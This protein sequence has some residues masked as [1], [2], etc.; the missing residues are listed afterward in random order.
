MSENRVQFNTIVSNQLPA[1]VREDFPL[2]ESFLES[3]YRGQEYQGGPVD[4]IQNI[5]KYTKVDNTTNLSSEIILEGDIDFDDTT[6]NVST[7]KSPTGTDGFPDSYGLIQID[8]EII[9]Y[10]GKTN[11]SFTG[12]IRGF[13][14]ITS[15]RSEIFADEVVFN[16]TS[17]EDHDSG[18]TIKNLSVLFLKDFLVKTKHQI[19]PGFEER[20]LDPD[21]NQKLFLKQSKDFYLT[22][23][24]DRSFEILF[25]ALYNENVE[26]IKPRDNLVTP[27]N[28]NF[29]VLNEMVVEPISGNPLELENA[30]L[31]QDQYDDIIEKAYAPISSVEKVD[32][33][34][35]QTF[36]RLT[37]DGGYNRDI[38]VDGS[39][40]GEFKVE[41]TTK[42]IGQVSAG[43]TVLDVDSTVGFSTDG[44]LYVVY[45]D[46]TNGVLSYT[47]KSLTQF[48]GVSNVN[49]TITDASTV[50]VNTFAYA[51][52]FDGGNVRVRINSVINK[53]NVPSN[54]KGH[55]KAETINIT[56][57]GISENNKKTNNW[58]YNLAPI[59]KVKD[60]QLI[61]SSNFTY[62]ITLNVENIFNGG[63]TATL[64]VSDGRKLTTTIIDVKTEKS[65][66]IRGQGQLNT[67]ST[68][69]I[70]RNIS[71]TKSNFFPS[72]NIFSTDIQ[73]VYKSV[74]GDDYLVAS[75]SIPSYKGQPL[76]TNSREI[77]FTGTFNGTEFIISPGKDHGLY[78]GDKVYYAA[79]RVSET[80]ID[81]FGNSAT[82]LVRGTGL[83]AD[84]EYFIERVNSFTVRFA[85]SKNNIFNSKYVNVDTVTTVNNSVV[86]PFEFYSKNLKPQNILRKISDPSDDGSINETKP[87][88]T[89]I[90]VNGVEILNYKSKQ[91]IKYGSIEEIEVTSSGSDLDVVNPPEL[92]ISDSVGTGATGYLAINGSLQEILI[93][94][95]GFDYLNTPTIKIDGGNGKGAT[96]SVNMKLIDHEP[97]FF[98]DNAKG[99]VVI[100]TASTQSRIGFSTYH[101]FKNAEEVIYITNNQEGIAGIV[102]NAQ[103]YVSTIDDVTVSLHPKQNDAI[104][105]INTVFLS[106]FGVGKHSLKSTSKKSVVDSINVVDGGLGY[107]NK[108]RTAA[109]TSGVSTAS[110]T[111]IISNHDYNSGELV[112]YTCV[113][114][115]ISG[116]NVDTDYYITK[117]ND[118]SFKLSQ[119]GVT[120]DKQLYYRTK[121]YVNLTSVGVGTHVFNY[122]DITVTLKGEV[123]ISSI[124]S[125]TFE[126]S[127][128]PVF[129]GSVTSVHLE[130][131]GVGYGSSEIL[132]LDHQPQVTINSGSNCQLK[133]II[134]NGRIVQVI[135]QNS[136][137]GYNSPPD[138]DV[139]G[140]G[141]GA[142]I[143]L[144]IVNGSVS[145]VNIIEKGAG[146]S[147]DTTSIVI[148]PSGNTN[149]PKFKSNLKTWRV[150][151]FEKYLQYF[152]SDDGF[153]TD[154][155]VSS[156]ELQYAHLYAPRKLRE[157]I[158]AVDQEGNKLYGE[159][160]LR[161]VNGIEQ[162]S[163]KHSPIIGFAYDGNPIYGPY[164]YS[165]KS[166]GTITQLK[167]GY[168][169]DIKSNRPPTSIFPEGFFVE[170]YTHF[171]V[172]D[173]DVLDA[174]NGRFCITPEYPNGTYA[175]FTTINSASDNSGV[176]EK[177]KK[178][179]FPYLI[180]NS[181][182]SIPDEY[183][184]K[185][186]SLQE[187][188]NSDDWR[189]NTYPY[190]VIEGELE[191]SY[192]DVPNKL[193]QSAKI[194]SVQPGTVN[195][196]GI[197]SAGVDY[198]IGDQV[199][200]D[201][202]NTRGEGISAKVSHLKGR[203]VNTVSVATSTLSNVEIYS[204]DV[205]GEYVVYNDKPHNFLNFNVVTIAGLSTTSSKI[206]GTYKAGITTNRLSIV[207]TG[208]TGVAIGTVGV[209]GLVTFFGVSGDL[210]FSKVR[211]ND[212]LTIGE[213]K[214]QVLNVD[215]KSSRIRVLREVEGTT[216]TSHT[217]GKY[218]FEDPRKLIINAGFKTD[219]N[220]RINKQIYFNPEVIGLGTISGV[221][222]GTTISFSN[223]GA[224]L[225]SIFI[226]SKTIFIENHDLKT[227]DEITYSPGTGGSG[228]IVEDSTNVGVGIT[229]TDGQKVFVAKIDD[230][231][232]GIATVR[233]GLGTTGT[234]VGIASTH[235]SATTL[236]FRSVGS[237]TTHSFK[238]N[239]T[240]LTGEVRRNLV[241]VSAASTHGLSSPHNI[242]ISVSPNNTITKILKYNDFNRR[243]IVDPVGFTTVGVNT[244]NN[245]ISVTSHGFITGDKIIHTSSDPTQ[246][247]VDQKIYYIVK[248]DNNT[249]KLA[250]TKHD[251]TIEKPN[252]VGLSSA[253][254]GTINPINP[255]LKVYKN[256]TVEFDLSD[257]S[258]GYTVQGT[259]YPAFEFNLYT[260]KNFTK[261]W[262]KSDT[263][264]V[265]ELTKTGNVGS[266]GAK[267]TL[268]VNKNLP[269]VLYYK[270]DVIKESSTPTSK[271]SIIVDEEANSNNE[272]NC[273]FSDY[274][275]TYS[276]NVGTTTT[277]TYTL[278]DTPEST[279]YTSPTSTIEYE[280]DCT[281]TYGPIAKVSIETP[282]KNYYSLPGITTVTTAAGKNAILFTS[283]ND[284]GKVKNIDI[285]NIDNYKLPSDKTLSPTARY[286][287]ILKID[288]LAQI[289][290]V[291]ISSFGRGYQIAPKLI[292]I[293][294]KTNNVV[295]DIDLRFANNKIDILKNTNGISNATPTIIP[296]QTDSGV[297]INTIV[298]DSSSGNVDVTLSVGFS[299]VN[300]F[301][302]K[303]GDKVLV[304][305]VSVGLGS[306]GK[307]FDSANYNYKLFTLTAVT[308]NLGGIGSVRYNISDSLTGS[309]FPGTFDKVNSSGRITAEK[310]FAIF[311]IKL[312]TNNYI[313]GETVSSGSKVGVVDD[314]DPK[315][316]TLTISSNDVFFTTDVIKGKTSNISGI[317]TSVESFDINT[318]VNSSVKTIKG[319]QT[320][321]G[322]LNFDLQ[323][324]QDS[325]YYQNFSY[326]LKSRVDFDTWNDPVSTTNHTLGFRKF[327]DYQLES[328]NSN[329]MTV[330]VSTDLTNLTLIKDVDSFVS[331]NCVFDFDLVKENNFNLNNKLVSDE[332]I[333]SN[334]ILSDFFESVGNRVLSIDDVSSQ[335]NSNPRPTTFSVIN[336]FN[337]NEIRSQKYIT[338]VGDKRF[339]AQRQLLLIDLIHDGSRGYINQ[340]GRVESQ[341]DQGS[342][343]FAIASGQGELRFFPTKFKVNDYNVVALSYNLDDVFAGVGTTSLGGVALIES[344]SSPITAGVTTNIVSI[345]STYTSAKVL[346]QINPDTSSNEEFETIELN[347]VHDGSNVELLDY[348]R[349]STGLAAYSEVGLGTYHAYIDGSDLKVDFVPASTGIGTTGVIN[350]IQVGLASDTFTG[351]GTADL[352]NSRIKAETTSISSSATPGIN[353]ISQ[354]DGAFDG[355]YFLVQ[356][357][358]TTNDNYQ[359]SEIVLLDDYTTDTTVDSDTYMTEYGV[360]ETSTTSGFGTFGS[361]V[362]SAGTVSL[363]YT[364]PAS[365]NTVV[366]VYSNNLN[367]IEDE[368]KSEE[369][370]FTNGSIN[371]SL[372]AYQGTES[373][374]KREFELK[375]ENLQ[376]FERYFEGNDSSIVS[377]TNNTIKI[378]NHFFVS[379]EKIRYV[380][381][382]STT[383][384]V[385]IATTS[386]V[387]ASSTTFLPGEN[388][389]AVKVDD[390]NIKIAS[391]A[392]NA[393]KSIPQIVELESVG[394]GTSHRFIA[395]NQNAKVIVAIDNLIQSP[396]VSTAVTTTLADS[397]TIADNLLKFSGITSFFG[398][399]I[400]QIGNEIMKIEGVGIGST[401]LIR[402]RRPWLGTKLSG[403]STGALVTKIVGN[404]NIVDNHLNFVEAPFGNTPIGS[405]TNAPD[406]RDW[407]GITTSS[408]FQG[409]SFI[410]SGITNSSDE[411]Y[412]KNYIFDDISQGFNGT[413]NEFRLY[414]NS[415]DVTGISTENAIILVNDVFQ[416]PGASNQYSLNE[417]AGITSVTFNGTETDPLGSDV[418]ISS[419]PKGGIIVSVGS[420][421]GLGYQPLVAAGGTA[422]VSGLGTI[423]S[424]SIGNSGSGYRSGI[425]TVNVG[426]GLSATGTPSIEFI[427]TA[428]VSNGNVVSVAITNPGT[429]YTT[430]NIPYVVFDQ[431][432]SYSNLTLE[433]SSSSVSGV[434]TEAKIDIVVGQ[435]SSVIDFEITNTGY[436]FGNGEILTVAIGGTTGIPTT[437]SFSGNEFQITIDEIATDEFTGWSLGTLQ[438]MDD[439]SEFIDGS[440]RN[441]NLLQNGSAVSIVAAKGSKI[442]VQDVLLIFVN[443]IL[444]V[445]GEGYTF[446]GGNFV[447]FTEAPKVGD[448]VQILF[449]KGSGD[450]DV[451]FKEVIETV[452]KG[453]T[454]QIKHNSSTQDSFLTEDERSVTLINS[455]SSVQTNPYY[456]PGN[457][458]NV[459]LERPVTWCRQTEDK[460]IDE[461]PVGK[462]RELYE[463]VI[464]SSAYII[465]SVGVGSTA[466]YVDNLRPIFNSQN[467]SSNLDFQNKIKFVSEN[468]NKVAAAATAIVSG[469]GTISSISITES[470]SGYDSA[471][472]VT[473]GNISQSVGLGTTA[474]ATA[475]ITSG[476]VTS[477]TLTNAGTGYTTSNPPSVLIEPHTYSQ[478]LCDVSSYAGDSGVIVGFG[479]TTI[480][481]VDEVIVDLHV[482]YESF[483]RNADLVGTAVTLSSLSVN[484]YFTIFNSNASVA[485]NSSVNTFDTTAT[486]VIGL[487]THFIDTIHQAKRVE[488][489]SRN[490]GGISTSVLRVNSVISGIGTINFSVDT[491]TMDDITVTMDESGSSISYSGGITTSNYFGEFS[492]GRINL[493]G[494]TKNNSYSANTLNGITGIST[495]DSLIRD[496]SLKFKNYLI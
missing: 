462:D 246:G 415:T 192:I 242:S 2:V 96:A 440:R 304:E 334:R 94:N 470:G 463:P 330:G 345:A 455:T 161:Q 156:N 185:N 241:T 424:I 33:G 339:T 318:E 312:K 239:H 116:L 83:F 52:T 209:T 140:D 283:S 162:S 267:A 17:A 196:I 204:S 228:I 68:F 380:H 301:P 46:K 458:S 294:G 477:V 396:V 124:G 200:F 53:I 155:R 383:S 447:T 248:V 229:L 173:D 11:F 378:P 222:I 98:A 430:S 307:G 361:R 85:K 482:P 325:F 188:L 349:L 273:R 357:V 225:T 332:I 249:I 329:N 437:S 275:G 15:Y 170:D 402:V 429:G 393:L 71:K 210:S 474:T 35:G 80:F 451:V 397:V 55:K 285:N 120:S 403:F 271:T 224:G 400:I 454:L 36:Y 201:N 442:N 215:A 257:S 39:A 152:E 86:T 90:L 428:V 125:E 327:A 444:Q 274:N 147:Q 292:V 359:L 50:G 64:V 76:N 404:Y 466:I 27:S 481:G 389:Y 41:P 280:T 485:G 43:A 371:N 471:P 187:K 84:G 60:I 341:Y 174:N 311:D 465:K 26:V 144:N 198:R 381:V 65:F 253:S 127:I 309:E 190:N 438:V 457:T 266:A 193:K 92:V 154:S 385:G 410:R 344:T 16:T 105:G 276:I 13:A 160:D 486:N 251:A 254:L 136:G 19:L 268:T 324:I 236:F 70:Q 322:V 179:V 197:S 308:E 382:G 368:D 189:R 256:S 279:S 141:L 288:R 291:A 247:L 408:S 207:G 66:T 419:F 102:T 45:S 206:E 21:L 149:P 464:N 391:S 395:T 364:P 422:V 350:T 358:D 54:T 414:Q 418:G 399:D 343:D 142:V 488:V 56:S 233:V 456:G 321:S 433:Y 366:N 365:V 448:R 441:F 281:H 328:N 335:F 1:Y 235:R 354:F 355:G 182:Q 245:T 446:D 272:I 151:L 306:T 352:T 212:I 423:Q 452:K 284:I 49:K 202:S 78:T 67:N 205:N 121:Q 114:T 460:I 262:N 74:N 51:S 44:D 159:S 323:R 244:T 340:Y 461:I 362:S 348:G 413:Q 356:V 134:E 347:I 214:V 20:S 91:Q 148:T 126:A 375:H 75:P 104:L 392:E 369:I 265:F 18:A 130:N 409:R 221:G 61:D 475:T 216:G 217:I 421:E 5:D 333:F 363:V 223:P 252:V 286:P 370:D 93:K 439:V 110:N 303:V 177:Y 87:G 119:V 63:D 243:V 427:G 226:P 240:V 40:Y 62:E 405:S 459:D 157:N 379:G 289:D 373:D 313:S 255:S 450:T 153:I 360:I 175:Y 487:A 299:T 384:A 89:G 261:V 493:N 30:T 425:Q 496:N 48:F 37:F 218:I 145:S 374:I 432:L 103:Y 476:E 232:I 181:Y 180:G 407:T 398:S 473:I 186:D 230:N 411:A 208:T 287:Q 305:N 320:D 469:L 377:V 479:T 238:T 34:F 336:S 59:Y 234:F 106:S 12:C 426:V 227:G 107:Q 6:I 184:F 117:E 211:D 194:N 367:L 258:L 319:R 297:G 97:E 172:S 111:I 443:N 139:I 316:D 166:G 128:T 220:F 376:V 467:E 69:E 495:S 115:P 431:P 270:L 183:N 435:G 29:S 478:E 342:F 191:Y 24:T 122:P 331:L 416:T 346:V 73:N 387:G 449:Y 113:G 95:S 171:E 7:S 8:D 138:V 213:E 150:N 445:P 250:N 260:D 135:V 31:Y 169:I 338:L 394:I 77:K 167:S 390:N 434:G 231:L 300:S 484:D 72:A 168:K 237:G 326:S 310:N 298:Y 295:N 58:I 468:T 269:D 436:G 472:V 101:K 22:K 293:D 264:S 315:I 100:G 314:W 353:T 123:G 143:T 164:G 219:Y 277:F 282:G 3:Y 10:T 9:T 4:L 133:P 163:T 23:G 109:A 453:D 79:E 178:P 42:V 317:A 372:G 28:A 259:Q 99:Q 165:S 490:V 263:N 146:Y 176:F 491:I 302:F 132:N 88:T 401:N 81:E 337:T 290:S 203:N 137:S 296:T 199:V 82:R 112:R 386:F 489:V 420:T 412:H 278:G 47:S 195:L 492:W 129:R 108:K 480:S 158:F 483:L 14:G 57:L 494:R 406:E 131:S 351:I 38:G 32:V 25:K 118:N 388:L 417:S